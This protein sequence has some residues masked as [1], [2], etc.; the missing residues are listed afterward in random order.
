[1][2]CRNVH[3]ARKAGL[4]TRLHMVATVGDL[5]RCDRGVD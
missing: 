4:W 5:K 3:L 2:R 1:M